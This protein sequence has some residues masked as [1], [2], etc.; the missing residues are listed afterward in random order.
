MTAYNKYGQEHELRTRRNS[1]AKCCNELQLKC[2]IL[3]IMKG[4][5]L[6][7]VADGIWHVADVR[8]PISLKANRYTRV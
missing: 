5:S 7:K 4:G 6:S 8:E 3:P 2:H 1:N